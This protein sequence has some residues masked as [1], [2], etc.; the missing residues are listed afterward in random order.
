M[1]ELTNYYFNF[2]NIRT[3]YFHFNVSD[4]FIGENIKEINIGVLYSIG[5]ILTDN[6]LNKKNERNLE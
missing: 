5:N 3:K 2:P 6:I 1:K 4:N